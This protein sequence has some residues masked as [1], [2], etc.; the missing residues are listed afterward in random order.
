MKIKENHRQLLIFHSGLLF[1]NNRI[2][3][4][5]GGAIYFLIFY[6]FL[7]DSMQVFNQNTYLRPFVFLIFSYISGFFASILASYNLSLDSTYSSLLFTTLP[8]LNGFIKIRYVVVIIINFI[9]SFLSLIFA[10]IADLQMPVFYLVISTFLLNSGFNSFIYLFFS[11]YNKIYIN[12]YEQKFLNYDLTT[13]NSLL[14]P[15]IQLF[16]SY[17]LYYLID[18]FCKDQRITCICLGFIGFLGV[19]FYKPLLRFIERNIQLRKYK[20]LESF[21]NSAHE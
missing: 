3:M 1:R 9:G 19:I 15:V 10:F 8:S 4:M 13:I 12:L 11:K 7:K 6:F 21:N 5:I 2:K 16:I 14:I 20:L 18:V 17:T